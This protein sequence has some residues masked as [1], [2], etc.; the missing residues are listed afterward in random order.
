MF[1]FIFFLF[2]EFH[3]QETDKSF[4]DALDSLVFDEETT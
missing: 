4:F 1:L 2:S 3:E